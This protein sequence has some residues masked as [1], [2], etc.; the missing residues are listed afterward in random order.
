[1]WLIFSMRKKNLPI[2]SETIDVKLSLIYS[3]L[4]IIWKHFLCWF[5]KCKIYWNLLTL[6]IFRRFIIWAVKMTIFDKKHK[7]LVMWPIISQQIKCLWRCERFFPKKLSMTT[8]SGENIF[9]QKFYKWRH[10]D[11]KWPKSSNSCTN[12]VKGRL[13]R[14]LSQK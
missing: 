13:F 14:H 9:F 6:S 7:N 4:Y 5:Q 10:N 1:M 2:A 12:L 8:P 3:M 11:R